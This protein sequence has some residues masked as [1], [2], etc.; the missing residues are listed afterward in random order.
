MNVHVRI[1]MHYYWR[2]CARALAVC[3]I[4]TLIF[5]SHKRCTSALFVWIKTWRAHARAGGRYAWL[6]I[7]IQKMQDASASG[8]FPLIYGARF[9]YYLTLSICICQKN[10]TIASKKIHDEDRLKFCGSNP[11]N[12]YFMPHHSAKVGSAQIFEIISFLWLFWNS[13]LFSYINF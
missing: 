2:A 3:K 4:S 13:Y 6:K 12:M 11:R 1:S 5:G 10:V 9:D 7:Y 8:K